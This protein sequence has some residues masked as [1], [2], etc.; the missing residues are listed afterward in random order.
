MYSIGS[1]AIV[2]ITFSALAI[3]FEHN[4]RLL[5]LYLRNIKIN[6]IKEQRTP[7]KKAIIF[8]CKINN[9]KI[10]NIE[11]KVFKIKLK[12]KDKMTENFFF[13][14]KEFSKIKSVIFIKS[15]IEEIKTRT[16]KINPSAIEN[17]KKIYKIN[18]IIK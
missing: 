4:H 18:A 3:A 16:P 1:L 8:A 5:S 10:K 9:K 14:F 6:K 7:I 12:L 11:I 17:P 15:I 2:A 13:E